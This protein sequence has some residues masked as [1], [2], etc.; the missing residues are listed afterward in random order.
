MAVGVFLARDNDADVGLSRSSAT[1]VRLE[2]SPLSPGVA[3]INFDAVVEGTD[4]NGLFEAIVQPH[5]PMAIDGRHVT[6]VAAGCSSSGKSTLM[7]GIALNAGIIEQTLN[8]VFQ[9]IE[10]R[11][12]KQLTCAYL[13]EMNCTLLR[14][15]ESNE[16]ELN[17]FTTVQN[18]QD[19]LRLYKECVVK[20]N[21]DGKAHAIVRVRIEGI[22]EFNCD[23]PSTI[24]AGSITLVD[25]A[26]QSMIALHETAK[27]EYFSCSPILSKHLSS[28]LLPPYIP[29]LL[30]GLR[31]ARTHQQQAIQSLLYACRVKDIIP[32]KEVVSVP[33]C[34]SLLTKLSTLITTDIWLPTERVL[35]KNQL[36][37]VL[38][39]PKGSWYDIAQIVLTKLFTKPTPLPSPHLSAASTNPDDDT[40]SEDESDERESPRNVL[41]AI[42]A[43]FGT[44]GQGQTTHEANPLTK[45]RMI[46][47]WWKETYDDL[48][49]EEIITQKCSTRLNQLQACIQAQRKKYDELAAEKRAVEEALNTS[50]DQLRHVSSTV[51]KLQE[52]VAVM[53]RLQKRTPDVNAQFSQRLAKVIEDT[54]QVVIMKDATITQLQQTI[55]ELQKQKEC[56]DFGAQTVELVTQTTPDPKQE[57]QERKILALEKRAAEAER[58]EK[59]AKKELA[60]MHIKLQHIQIK[61]EELETQRAVDLSTHTEWIET[62]DKLTCMCQNLETKNQQ[63]CMDKAALEDRVLSEQYRVA[64]FNAALLRLNTQMTARTSLE[65]KLMDKLQGA[66]ERIDRL[67]QALAISNEHESRAKEFVR[68]LESQVESMPELRRENLHLHAVLES[69]EHQI[70]QLERRL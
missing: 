3:S 52:D 58:K 62:I 8:L 66:E 64:A 65:H 42:D 53:K 9:Q 25:I 22:E 57:A 5:V 63:H 69:K 23:H 27:M 55:Q 47:G 10:L 21:L 14:E 34:T 68:T 33:P 61:Y 12:Q 7:H 32:L 20:E 41:A 51:Q 2:P 26:G 17:T 45:L 35:M 56:Q 40:S 70:R 31:T 44:M 37:K 36:P 1:C 54:K 49:D 4:A 16:H 46:H 24:H 11:L 39:H 29:C 28:C 18:V 59:N 13:I 60:S 38:C 30:M 6:V 15:N 48:Q 19:A 50:N 67:V 43:L